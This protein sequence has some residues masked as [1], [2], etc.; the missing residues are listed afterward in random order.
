MDTC[1]S[2]FYQLTCT[3]TN[4]RERKHQKQREENWRLLQQKVERLHISKNAIDTAKDSNEAEYEE[5]DTSSGLLSS[6]PTGGEYILVYVG[7]L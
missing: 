6:S 3:C 5:Y 1:S 7:V 2:F 4:F